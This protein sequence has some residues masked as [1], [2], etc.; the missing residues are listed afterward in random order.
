MT[1][2]PGAH[3]VEGMSAA[4][5]VLSPYRPF[6]KWPQASQDYQFQRAYGVTVMIGIV[7]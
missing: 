3:R 1:R 4:W 2:L 6:S 7:W 5:V